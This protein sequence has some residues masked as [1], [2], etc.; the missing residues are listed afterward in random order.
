MTRETGIIMS[1]NHPKL[2]LDGTK[3]MTRRT[4]GLEKINEN[5]NAWFGVPENIEGALWRFHN[6]NGT[7]LIVKCPYG[8]VGYLLWVRETWGAKGYGR[9]LPIDKATM[10]GRLI[11]GDDTDWQCNRPS[12]FMPRWASRI[13]LEITSLRAERLQEISWDDL[14]KEGVGD[15][16]DSK[17]NF[18]HLWDS[19]NAKPKPHYVKGEIAFYESYPWEDIQETRTYRGKPWYV[20][21]NPWVWVMGYKYSTKN[22]E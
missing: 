2:I 6:Y 17:Y 10:Q 22:T 13:T 11:Y 19:L 14:V 7:S 8:Q 3:T 20:H 16:R 18:T 1:G 15:Y 21:G 5:P 12:I 9:I 4:W